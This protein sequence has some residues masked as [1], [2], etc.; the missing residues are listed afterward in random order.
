MFYFND[1]KQVGLY[2]FID[3]I[4]SIEKSLLVK[5]FKPE[6]YFDKYIAYRNYYKWYS[7]SVD[8]FCTSNIDYRSL[9]LT[10]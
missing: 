7:F 6:Y 2:N 1:P 3:L 10:M 4:W 9:I 5:K 8:K